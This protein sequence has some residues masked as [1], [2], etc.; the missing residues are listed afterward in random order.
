MIPLTDNET[1]FIVHD[2]ED[3][4]CILQIIPFNKWTDKFNWLGIITREIQYNVYEFIVIKAFTFEE[5]DYIKSQL[6]D[7]DF[8][9]FQQEVFKHV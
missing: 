2:L 8:L 1:F 6:T 3:H 9:K 7:I 5:I 4:S